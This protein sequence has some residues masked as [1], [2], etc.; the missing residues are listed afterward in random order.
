MCAR[1][2]VFLCFV[3]DIDDLMQDCSNSIA[4]ALELLESCTKPSIYISSFQ[5]VYLLISFGGVSLAITMTSQITSLTIVYSTVY[6]GADQSNHQS[7]ASLAFVWGIHRWPS[8]SPHIWPVT[9]TCFHLMTSSWHWTNHKIIPSAINLLWSIE[10]TWR[11]R[12]GSTL[13]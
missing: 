4:N 11:Q 6:S 8:N 12:S 9:R 7:S 3:V 13:A 10:T 5:V 1:G 2:L